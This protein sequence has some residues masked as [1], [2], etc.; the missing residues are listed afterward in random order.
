MPTKV[1]SG[2]HIPANIRKIY[3]ELD[4]SPADLLR[5]YALNHIHAK[6]QKYEAENRYYRDKHKD[7]FEAFRRKVQS[8]KD[9]EDFAREDDLMDWEFAVINLRYWKKKAR[10]LTAE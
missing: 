8:L 2:L 7:T 10:E 4:V 9:E 5:N 3:G 1:E 6:I